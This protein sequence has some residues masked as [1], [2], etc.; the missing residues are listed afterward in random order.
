MSQIY[1]DNT[2]RP[3]PK[4]NQLGILGMLPREFTHFAGNSPEGLGSRR[5]HRWDYVS[6]FENMPKKLLHLSPESCHNFTQWFR[7]GRSWSIVITQLR[8]VLRLHANTS[9]PD[10]YWRKRPSQWVHLE[11]C[12]R[13]RDI[14]K[15]VLN[16]ITLS[17]S[18]ARKGAPMKVVKQ[19][20]HG[21][22]ST[23]E[24]QK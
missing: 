2:K 9:S 5:E 12:H 24:E 23:T 13:N 11:L 6:L 16:Q 15:R 14:L 18:T 7:E 3:K 17:N 19:P 10:V 22:T 20:E 1:N 8:L 4:E 21:R